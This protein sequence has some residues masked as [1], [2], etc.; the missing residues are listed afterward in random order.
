MKD[1]VVQFVDNMLLPL[2]GHYVLLSDLIDAFRRFAPKEHVDPDE[3]IDALIC[4]YGCEYGLD[5]VTRQP[6]L[7]NVTLQPRTKW[8]ETSGVLTLQP[9]DARN[10]SYRGAA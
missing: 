9:Y 7:G 1:V 6:A 4:W 8:Q 5:P 3:I 10:F 2:E